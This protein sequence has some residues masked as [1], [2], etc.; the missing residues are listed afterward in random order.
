MEL[1]QKSESNVDTTQLT[2]YLGAAI[3]VS[4]IALDYKP[5]A[6][7]MWQNR[8]RIFEL[9][10][11]F[12]REAREFA[13]QSYTRATELEPTNAM[14]WYSVG[15][16]QRL[17]SLEQKQKE[18]QEK[19]K[20]DQAKESEDAGLFDVTLLSEAKINLGKAIALKADYFAPYLSL[21]RI[22]EN[23]N[24]LA[25][26]VD[27]LTTALSYPQNQTPSTLYELARLMYNKELLSSV[28][29]N[30]DTLLQIRSLLNQ[31]AA[32][33]P[34]FANALYMRA[35]VQKQLGN[36]ADAVADMERVVELNPESTE[37]REKLGEL[38][39]LFV[40][41]SVTL[42]PAESSE[43][44]EPDLEFDPGVEEGE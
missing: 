29:Q 1:T 17:F 15:E 3:N 12:A 35:L 18:E 7:G 30:K 44:I 25:T 24:D 36:I 19:D 37:A 26:A 20:S 8:G 9:V 40:N 16:N 4:K 21:A 11:P 42:P 28:N 13:I 23:E 27:R 10:S 39:R 34:D 22:A 32:G 33:S 6:V 38:R 14:L 43:E 5:Q 41:V 2:N 31:A